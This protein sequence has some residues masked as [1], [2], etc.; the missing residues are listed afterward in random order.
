MTLSSFM[1][2]ALYTASFYGLIAIGYTMVFGIMKLINYAH[3]EVM[4][5]GSFAAYLAIGLGPVAA[6]VISALFCAALGLFCERFI[7]RPSLSRGRDPLICAVGFSL[8]LQYGLAAVFSSAPISATTR[9]DGIFVAFGIHAR[10][11]TAVALAVSSTLALTLFL[12]Y[13]KTGMAMRAAASDPLSAAAC[14]IDIKAM[15][16]LCFAIGS[17]VAGITGAAVAAFASISPFMNADV[18]MKAFCCAVIG[19]VG[20]VPGAMLGGAVVS[21]CETA[22]SLFFSSQYKD[23]VTFIIL[24]LSLSF[25]PNGIVGRRRDRV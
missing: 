23:A 19:G 25:F 12:R 24:S 9:Y 18:G 6:A 20:S 4:T 15:R 17:A 2:T 8:L 1:S 13:T 7:Y 10:T 5:V 21:L 3:G 16:A 22:T 11:V 14:G